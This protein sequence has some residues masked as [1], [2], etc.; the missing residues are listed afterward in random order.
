MKRWRGQRLR[1]LAQPSGSDLTESLCKLYTREPVP[2]G[3]AGLL[4]IALEVIWIV[5]CAVACTI[6]I[7]KM[8]RE[9]NEAAKELQGQLT[10]RRKA[11]RVAHKTALAEE[12]EIATT[13][14]DAHLPRPPATRVIIQEW[15]N[16]CVYPAHTGRDVIDSQ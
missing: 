12:A 11:K 7:S 6:L 2:G 9:R 16:A 4:H 5:L 13:F 14:P 8:A 3:L 10:A 1:R 15:I